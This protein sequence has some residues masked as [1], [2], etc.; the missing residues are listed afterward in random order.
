MAFCDCTT[1]YT[2]PNL[3]P[4]LGAKVGKV[5][6]HLIGDMCLGGLRELPQEQ[7]FVGRAEMLLWLHSNLIQLVT[8]PHR[9][10]GHRS[11]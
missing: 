2:L 10:S 1:S 4:F 11:S 7:G 6:F 5:A 8:F 9:E 3:G